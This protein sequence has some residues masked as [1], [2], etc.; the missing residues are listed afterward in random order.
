MCMV[1]CDVLLKDEG[2]LIIHNRITVSKGNLE[3]IHRRQTKEADNDP[4]TTQHIR[5][6]RSHTL[7]LHPSDKKDASLS[8]TTYIQS[9]GSRIEY[10]LG[11]KRQYNKTDPGE[12]MGLDPETFEIM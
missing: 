1:S 12:I 10:C 4:S 2:S 11:M 8:R 6:H 9:H 3:R 7:C 5:N